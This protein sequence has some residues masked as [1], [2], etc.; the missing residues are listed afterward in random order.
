MGV[1]IGQGHHDEERQ[2]SYRG[3]NNP[4]EVNKFNKDSNFRILKKAQHATHILKLV[5]TMCKSEMDPASIRYR[6]DATPFTDGQT[7]RWT[8]KVNQCTPFQLHWNRGITSLTSILW[9]VC[10]K[11]Y[12]NYK[13][14][15]GGPMNGAHSYSPSTPPSTTPSSPLTSGPHTAMLAKLGHILLYQSQWCQSYRK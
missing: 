10:Q 6:A 1:V 13:S 5:D 11:M 12:G 15:T 14:V 8:D 9:A 4:N 2:R 3:S 7:D